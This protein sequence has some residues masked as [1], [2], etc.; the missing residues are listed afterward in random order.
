[1]ME[2]K[3][4]GTEFVLDNLFRFGEIPDL[5]VTARFELCVRGRRKVGE[6][7]IGPVNLSRL[8]GVADLETEFGLQ[9]PQEGPFLSSTAKIFSG[10]T[11]IGFIDFYRNFFYVAAPDFRTAVAWVAATK[12]G[13]EKVL[14]DY[15]L[16]TEVNALVDLVT[17][18]PFGDED[19]V[20][21]RLFRGAFT[22]QCLKT[23]RGRN[24]ACGYRRLFWRVLTRTVL[25]CE[26]IPESTMCAH[27]KSAFWLLLGLHHAPKYSGKVCLLLS[28]T[29]T[30]RNGTDESNCFL[31]RNVIINF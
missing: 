6:R 5:L 15:D 19:P 18:K 1:M 30:V 7:V 11:E 25:G 3:T 27:L 17:E 14:Y 9:E 20:G 26:L 29:S 24:C 4:D 8:C 13:R 28:S 31:G 10:E 16:N 23:I 22:D 2:Y 21:A 12:L